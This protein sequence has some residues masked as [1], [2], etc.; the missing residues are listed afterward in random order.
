MDGINPHKSLSSKHSYCPIIMIIYNLSPWLCM[1]RK[2]MML[3][4]LLL[5]PQK[6]GNDI[7]VYLASLLEDLKTLWDVRVQAYDAHQQELFTL[8]VVLLWTINEFLAYGKL[9][10]CIVKGYFACPICGE[11]TYSRRLKYGKKRTHIRS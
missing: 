9:S 4:L 6:P 1:K 8:R 5:G 7:D 2:F 3:S 11:E 10:G